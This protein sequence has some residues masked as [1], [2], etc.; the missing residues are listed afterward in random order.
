MTQAERLNNAI[1][2]LEFRNKDNPVARRL[3]A[4]WVSWWNDVRPWVPMPVEFV[5]L[6][7]YWR[8]Y[9]EAYH[10]AANRQGVPTPAQAEPHFWKS[11]TEDVEMRADAF[12]DL[13][14]TAQRAVDQAATVASER[15]HSAARELRPSLLPIGIGL[16]IAATVGVVMLTK[17]AA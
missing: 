9:S 7:W 12:R 15:M 2:A 11:A 10:A 14:K 17:K 4:D 13:G 8:R 3:A 5:T 16:G 6:Q 1:S